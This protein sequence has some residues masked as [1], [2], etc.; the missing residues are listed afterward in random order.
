MHNT[1]GAFLIGR[2]DVSGYANG[3][4]D[5]VAY[6]QRELSSG[7]VATASGSAVDITSLNPYGWWRMGD[8]DGGSGTTIT[9]QGSGLNNATLVNGP[10][11]ADGI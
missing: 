3:R 2:W 8:N 11:F 5:E 4:I 7:E 6:F 10:A 9:D 1:T